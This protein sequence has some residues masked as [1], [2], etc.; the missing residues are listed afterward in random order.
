[1]IGPGGGVG[2]PAEDSVNRLLV[3]GGGGFVG[4]NLIRQAEGAW[5]VHAID[6]RAEDLH[7]PGLTWH[8]LDLNDQAQVRKVFES[9]RPTAVVHTAAASD[10]DWCEA[11]EEPARRV[12]VGVTALLA[13]LSRS[14]GAR[15]VYF[16]SDSIFDG[17][18]G[19]YSEEDAPEPLNV[20]ARTKVE[21]E[22]IVA[23][24]ESPWVIVR[25][26]LVLGLPVGEEGNSF[27]WRMAQSLK[28]GLTV[29]FP[30]GEIR[31]PIDVITLSRAV[32][33][34]AAGHHQGIYHLS[35][36]DAMTRF[37]MARRICA[38]LGYAS[39]LVVDKKPQIATGRAK[40]PANV[41]LSNAKAS[42]ALKTPMV[43]FDTGLELVI[44]QR[45]G[46]DL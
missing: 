14:Y 2:S 22:R 19:G 17:T 33:E 30:R 38:R 8:E 6:R 43:D 11:N 31:S 16:S 26:S 5:D 45:G 39:S 25:P 1:M 13:E 44:Q 15:L 28:K 27:L 9:V 29:A 23:R 20:Y 32:L 42:R 35:G 21:G 41:S 40:R 36:N 3:T 46:K 7:G 18:R 12:N 4:G 10:I 34:L 37:D 24:M